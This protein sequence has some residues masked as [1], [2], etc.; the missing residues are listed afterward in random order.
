MI[1][2]DTSGLLAFLNRSDPHNPAV[3]TI[4]RV[5][6]GPRYITTAILAEIAYMLEKRAGHAAIVDLI[7]DLHIGAYMR[8]CGEL[9]IFAG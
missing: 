8:D 3:T 7:D 6:R 5:E 1:T 4:L 2:L 9:E